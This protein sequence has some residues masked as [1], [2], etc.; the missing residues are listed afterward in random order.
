MDRT[1]PAELETIVLKAVSKNPADRYAT[2]REFADDLRR[3]WTTGRSWPGRR[4]WPSGWPQ[5]ARRHPSV[6][7]SGLGVCGL[8]AM[9]S[10]VAAAMIQRAYEEE[11]ETG[12]PGR[13]VSG[14]ARQSAGEMIEIGDRE[15]KRADQAEQAPELARQSADEMIEIGEQ[16]LAGKPGMEDLRKRMFLSALVY[17]QGLIKQ[18]A[19]DANAQADLASHRGHVKEILSDLALL[20]GGGRAGPAAPGR[21]EERPGANGL[22]VTAEQQARLD[23]LDRRRREGISRPSPAD[24]GRVAATAA[25]RRP[26]K[27][28]AFDTILTSQQQ[29]RLGQIA[30]HLKPWL[31]AFHEPEVAT[32][33]NLTASQKDLLKTVETEAFLAVADL[34]RGPG[35]PGKNV[36]PVFRAATEKFLAAL[37]DEQRRRGRT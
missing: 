4:A 17:Y 10:L 24:P 12:R 20:Q 9:V 13:A 22:G 8:T 27:E 34:R 11:A 25:R 19:D 29:R 28:D 14:V 7:V 33:L 5:A 35:E 23:D 3:S 36:E 37:T 30:L 32:T 6:V 15:R 1:V 31:S 2:A 26:R 21:R 18:C 16:E